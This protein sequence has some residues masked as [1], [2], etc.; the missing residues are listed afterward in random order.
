MLLALGVGG[1]TQQAVAGIPMLECAKGRENVFSRPFVTSS[2]P[3]SDVQV[4]HVP[5]VLLDELAPRFDLVA[6]QL[7]EQP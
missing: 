1:D 5:C 6:H 2:A 7:F 4:A 3:A